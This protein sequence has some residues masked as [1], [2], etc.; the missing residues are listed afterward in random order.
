M[1]DSMRIL[2]YNVQMRSALMEMGAPPSIPPVYTAPQRA[3]LIAQ[4]ILDSPEEIDVVCLNEVFD[5]PA[6]V[7]L[8]DLLST[9]FPYQVAKADTFHTRIVRPPAFVG[10]IVEDVWTLTLGE[11]PNLAGLALGKFEDSGLFLASRFPFATVPAP[12][13][14]IPL[15]P[16]VFGRKVPVVR[17][18]MYRDASDNDKFA[19]KGVLYVRLQPPDVDERHVFISHTQADT[20]RAGE[21]VGDRRKQMQDV[22]GFV[23]RCVEESPPFAKEVFFLG[24]LNVVGYAD[25]DDASHPSG[26]DPEWTTLFGRPGAPLYEQLVDRWGRDQCPGL[27][28]G[29]NDPGFTADAVYTPYRQ[30][31]DY[32]FSSATSRLVAQHVRIDR[33]LADPH[34]VLPYLSDHH[35]LRADFHSDEPFRTPATAFDIPNRVDFT[36]S[37]S[38]NAGRVDWYRVDE[39]G[40]Y[41]ID[42]FNTSAE[43]VFE[44]YLG[45]DF[46]TPQPPYRVDDDPERAP[47][48]VLVAPFFIKVFLPDRHGESN[49]TL[50]THRHEGRTW[51]DAIV[52]VPE[53]SRTEWFPNRRFNLNTAD[54]DWDDSDSK[55]FLVE[56]PRIPL[57]N[58]VELSVDVQFAVVVDA[59]VPADV[60]LTVGHWDG[61]TP[62]ATLLTEADPGS[63]PRVVWE[64]KENEHFFVLVRRL[65]DVSKKVSFTIVH[66]APINLLIARPAVDTTLTCQKET[67]GWGADDIALR[68]RADGT[69]IADVPNSI[70][71]DF[72]DDSV[73]TVGDKIAEPITTYLEGIEVDVIEEDDIDDNDVGTGV[74]PRVEDAHAAAG[75]TVLHEGI[76]GRI[77]GS[78]RIR[79][80]DGWYAFTCAISRWHPSA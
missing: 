53:Q 75:F 26:P 55:W 49:Y 73:R 13:A 24:D 4:A 2:T 78:L 68:V 38:L 51:R 16:T 11:L 25:L 6:R 77:S 39:A 31:L 74:I 41:D 23:E 50:R 44:V 15:L 61:V 34:G 43:V 17:F 27:V 79:V 63:D 19:A 69:V 33:A 32:V 12:P 40:T 35:P 58:P 56:T 42:L 67:S 47:R 59:G 36:R 7:V 65:T 3:A 66:R 52:L 71:G 20:D 9:E 54:A 45:D 62:P 5:E 8:S 1:S 29:R 28:S 72:E 37:S 22:A 80:D 57:P 30:R 60:Q 46:S 21:N 70:I 10:D 76:D 18:L 48:F 64:A 14:V